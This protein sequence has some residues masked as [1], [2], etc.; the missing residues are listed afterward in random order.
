MPVSSVPVKGW[1]YD[2]NQEW[3]RFCDI[4]WRCDR[5]NILELRH[6]RASK[7]VASGT[8]MSGG[9]KSCVYSSCLLS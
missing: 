3:N 4:E 6:E 8:S 7:G 2:W 5:S 1:L 9:K